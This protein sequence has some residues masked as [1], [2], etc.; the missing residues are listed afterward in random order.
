MKKICLALV[1][2]SMPLVAGPIDEARTL[3]DRG[4]YRQ[5]ADVLGSRLD[6]PRDRA[7]ALILLTRAFNSLGDYK[8]G[9]D[10]GKQAI[11]AAPDSAEAHLE[12]ARA[13]RIKMQNINKMKAMFVLGSYKSALRRSLELDPSNV[14]ARMEEIGF[15]TNAPG[16]AGGDLD[17]AEKRIDEL[18]SLDRRQAMFMRAALRSKQKDTEGAIATYREMV[19]LDENDADARQALAFSL[20]ASGNYREADQH[21]GHLLENDDVLRSMMARYQLARSRILGEYEPERAVEYLLGYIDELVEPLE[22]LPT[23]S[24]AYWRLGLAYRQLD[25]TGEARQALERAVA[26]DSENEQAKDALKALNRG[27]K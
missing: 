27:T 24:H 3:M 21:F 22:S 1:L 15:L 14:E 7:E 26:L 9:V 2:C 23:V 12:Y 10:H 6:H 25:R 5:A 18:V 8:Q 17:K 20:Q 19:E 13:L 11:E 16:V 4:E